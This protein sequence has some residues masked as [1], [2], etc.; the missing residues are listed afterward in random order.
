MTNM[1]HDRTKYANL[2]EIWNPCTPITTSAQVQAIIDF[3]S[4]QIGTCAMV[5]YPYPTEFIGSLPAWP[6]NHTCAM[7]NAFVPTPALEDDPTVS[8]YNFTHI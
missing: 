2:N 1:V 3:V 5:N 4:D 6:I 8:M 7:V